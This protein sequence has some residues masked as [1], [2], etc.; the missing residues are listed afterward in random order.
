MFGLVTLIQDLRDV[1]VHVDD[2]EKCD[3]NDG[4]GQLVDL[5]QHAAH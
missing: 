2:V 4:I 1:L 5:F 3:E